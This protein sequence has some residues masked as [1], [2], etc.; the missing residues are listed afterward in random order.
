MISR[1]D[2]NNEQEG[3]NDRSP[4]A[5]RAE[6]IEMADRSWE[7]FLMGFSIRI[8]LFPFVW[9]AAYSFLYWIWIIEMNRKSIERNRHHNQ[10]ESF[11]SSWTSFNDLKTTLP[12]INIIN[13]INIIYWMAKISQSTNWTSKINSFFQLLLT[14]PL[15]A[16]KT[17]KTKKTKP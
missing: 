13:I 8:L 14:L 11:W 9:Q 3:S 12:I 6:L 5:K 4:N 2:R 17:T 16:K 15:F 7:L 1:M 10:I